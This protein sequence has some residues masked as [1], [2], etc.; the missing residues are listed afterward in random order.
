MDST[1]DSDQRSRIRRHLL[2]YLEVVNSDSGESLG[3]IGDLNRSGF[4]LLSRKAFDTGQAVP[5]GIILPKQMDFRNTRLDL[6][7]RVRWCRMDNRPDSW[8]CGCEFTDPGEQELGIIDA[9]VGRLGFS[10]GTRRIFLRNDQ[11]V[12]LDTDSATGE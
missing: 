12:F 2:V 5:A 4:L 3:R 6:A 1:H 7:V 8:V 9:L 11:N 10:D